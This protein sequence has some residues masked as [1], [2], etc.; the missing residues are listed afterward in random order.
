MRHGKLL[1]KMAVSKKLKISDPTLVFVTTT[2]ENWKPIL[3]ERKLAEV[4]ALQ[5]NETAEYHNVSVVGYVIV[6]NHV[7]LL[8]S[9]KNYERLPKFIQS[10][11]SLTSP[12]LE[13]LLK[14][15]NNFFCL[16]LSKYSPYIIKN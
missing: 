16:P 9:F 8:L 1:V 2:T 4:I 14:Y 3:K 7:H 12:E 6:P 15:Y 5:L 11:K 13:F 10:F